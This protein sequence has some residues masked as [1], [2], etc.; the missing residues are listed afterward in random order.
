M[1]MG[2]D[3]SG[4][5][6]D[7][8]GCMNLNILEIKKM[9]YLYLINYSRSK[10]ELAAQAAHYFLRD[11]SDPNPLIRALALRTMG[12]I[13]VDKITESLVEPL[14]QGLQDQD[15]YVRK[16]AAVCVAKLYIH[17]RQLVNDE[18]FIPM[19]K[20]LLL[21][22]NPAV[23]ANAVS[24]LAEI[25]ERSPDLTLQL[26]MRIASKL[27]AALNECSEWGQAYVLDTLLYV[28]PQEPGDAEMLAER[29][30]PRLQ[31]ANSSVVLN[32]IKL[33]IY[34]MNYMSNEQD[35]KNF[36][37]KLSP[38]LVTLLSSGPEVQYVVLRNILLI[39]QKHPTVLQ[40]EIKVFFCKYNDPIYVKLAKLEI[41]F[42]LTTAENVN[43]VLSELVEYASEVDVD[44]VRKSV[45]AIGRL[46]I[47]IP[48]AT[49]KCISSLLDLIQ[50]KVNYVVQEGIVVIKDIFRKYP[51]KY[52]SIIGKLCENLDT[53]D[54]PEAK[55]AMI[56][57]LGQYADRIE[58][59][60]EILDG[61]LEN[62]L[63]E[64]PEVQLSL[65]TA[66]V[67][68]FIKRPT[69]GQN[70]VPKVLKWSTDEVDNPDLRDRGFIYWRLLSVDPAAAKAI[71]LSEKPE[72]STETE[73]IEKTLLDELL[74]HIS[75]L[76][77]VYHKVPGSFIP[78]AKPRYLIQS[79]V[80]YCLVYKGD[81][82][83]K[84]AIDNAPRKVPAPP[85][86]EEQKQAAFPQTFENT[87]SNDVNLD[88]DFFNND[89][90]NT[91]APVRNNH[92]VD[93]LE[94][95]D[96]NFDSP[97]GQISSTVDYGNSEMAQSNISYESNLLGQS[98]YN[99]VSSVTGANMITGSTNMPVYD[100]YKS[101]QFPGYA[102]SKSI[103]GLNDEAGNSQSLIHGSSPSLAPNNTNSPFSSHSQSNYNSFSEF[104]SSGNT[105]SFYTPNASQTM[106]TTSTSNFD[107]L[108][109]FSSNT[110]GGSSSNFNSIASRSN[111]TPFDNSANL[112][113]DDRLHST[114]TRS[115]STPF[116]QQNSLVDDFGNFNNIKFID[117]AN[118]NAFRFRK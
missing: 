110:M 19:L 92:M 79:K 35:V 111:S 84:E 69:A 47:K 68:L 3:M 116:N 52:E 6:Q 15:P 44:F 107:L 43:Q 56:W 30:A 41:I 27:I 23:V 88:T 36:T 98:G 114:P 45:R 109:D 21:D 101:S 54:E 48:S 14:R 117:L 53:L 63:E 75:T 32:A 25:S 31:H 105:S 76:S 8:I 66:V 29:I 71:V 51:N 18:G 115:M 86:A 97:M 95:D 81:E 74:F 20:D 83:T 78:N 103:F 10:P 49:Q 112:M 89:Y 2:N 4:L 91:A 82:K 70:L 102:T 5:F 12:Y 9:V 40:G 65:L 11:A 77:S 55:A 7:V 39:I 100:P 50:T 87:F 22:P 90:V 26:N 13:H 62:F 58:N 85:P 34:L 94:F 61:F 104:N 16:T 108:S 64:A 113:G 28:V 60:D 24:S 72:I 46:A 42:R 80:L 1:T 17:N 73:N 38:P 57:I 106:N 99:S 118:F 37:K 59:S 33:I 67:K 96:G 93:L